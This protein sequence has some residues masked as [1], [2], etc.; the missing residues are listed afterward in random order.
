MCLCDILT[1]TGSPTSPTDEHS[2]KGMHIH[3]RCLHIAQSTTKPMFA[4]NL[5]TFP[6]P[7]HFYSP[8]KFNS[9]AQIC[10]T[11][12]AVLFHQDILTFQVTVGNS[13]FALSA[14]DLSVQVAQATN[15]GV[16]QF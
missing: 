1:Y 2:L 11:A 15:G 9:Q 5:P 10:Y 16:S 4:S 3:C 8:D 13:G 12:G 7:P 6:H 14:E